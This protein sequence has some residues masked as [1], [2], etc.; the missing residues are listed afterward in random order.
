MSRTA[1]I[2]ART[3]WKFLRQAEASIFDKTSKNFHLQV[4]APPIHKHVFCRAP[5]IKNTQP[6]L[7]KTNSH[8]HILAITIASANST[9]CKRDQNGGEIRGGE[10]SRER[11]RSR[12][13]NSGSESG[14]A[15]RT[16]FKTPRL[17][18]K[19]DREL[20]ARY[21]SISPLSLW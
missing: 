17:L 14:A 6:L 7:Y 19:A 10:K 21:L 15:K 18:G 20:N 11:R 13:P 8:A 5:I 2:P 16:D 3:S 4:L 1:I 12:K 9:G